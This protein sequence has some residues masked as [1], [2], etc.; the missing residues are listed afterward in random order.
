MLASLLAITFVMGSWNSLLVRISLDKKVTFLIILN[1]Y[2]FWKEQQFAY[3]HGD[4]HYKLSELE[5]DLT[6]ALCFKIPLVSAL[7]IFLKC[8][9]YFEELHCVQ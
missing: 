6:L 3:L 5:F 9:N 2:L 8:K 7:G 1:S 4:L